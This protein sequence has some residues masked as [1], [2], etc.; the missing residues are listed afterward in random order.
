MCMLITLILL[1][2][3]VHSVPQYSNH[4]KAF[5]T[6]TNTHFLLSADWGVN[7]GN[8]VQCVAE[9]PAV[10]TESTRPTCGEGQLGAST[11]VGRAPTQPSSQGHAVSWPNELQQGHCIKQNNRCR[12]R[13]TM[14]RYWWFLTKALW[15]Q[16][17]T[18]SPPL[19]SLNLETP[20]Q[21]G[22]K[23]HAFERQNYV[24]SCRPITQRRSMEI[25]E[26]WHKPP[27]YR[28]SYLLPQRCKAVI[29]TM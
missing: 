2:V 25:N 9:A 1:I 5:F 26:R 6:N 23:I 18:Q 7:N 19:Q 10:S 16:S 12:C 20:R 4:P 27:N 29:G 24:H 28:C 21:I 22:W 17:P 8:D 3:F 13:N 11:N 15:P 14:H